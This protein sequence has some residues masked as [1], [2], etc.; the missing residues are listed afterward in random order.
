MSHIL[1]YGTFE[2]ATHLKCGTYGFYVPSVSQSKPLAKIAAGNVVINKV[3]FIFLSLDFYSVPNG[4]LT[5]N[6]GYYIVLC[7]KAPPHGWF[8]TTKDSIILI[9]SVGSFKT[10]LNEYL[11]VEPL[12]ASVVAFQ[13]LSNQ[14][15]PLFR[16]HSPHF[17]SDRNI[18]DHIF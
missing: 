4:I 15:E 14:S 10:F 7:S 12:V 2:A 11:H 9:Y 1:K 3:N 8:Q 16:F 6:L 18:F 13:T 17:L 5:L